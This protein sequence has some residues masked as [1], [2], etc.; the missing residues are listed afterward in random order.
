MGQTDGLIFRY[1]DRLTIIRLN[2]AQF[3]EIWVNCSLVTVGNVY[4]GQTEGRTADT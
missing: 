3:E 1:T 4:N 2:Y